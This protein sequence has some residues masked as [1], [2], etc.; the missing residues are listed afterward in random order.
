MQDSFEYIK[1]KFGE[2]FPDFE[3]MFRITRWCDSYSL[4]H[5]GV[6]VEILKDWVG[7]H[8]FLNRSYHRLKGLRVLVWRPT[9]RITYEKK[10]IEEFKEFIL[11]RFKR[12]DPT[13]EFYAPKLGVC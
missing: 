4:H 5:G 6:I 11:K 10:K 7:Y 8:I 3:F 9:H 12:Y 2:S 1:V 13:I